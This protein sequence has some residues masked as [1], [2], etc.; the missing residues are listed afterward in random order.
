MNTAELGEACRQIIQSGEFID[1][2]PSDLDPWTAMIVQ[3]FLESSKLKWQLATRL[4][5]PTRVI[6]IFD[7]KL[8]YIISMPSGSYD[9]QPGDQ[10]Y[11]MIGDDPNND[12]H[13]ISPEAASAYLLYKQYPGTKIRDVRKIDGSCWT[14]MTLPDGSVIE[15]LFPPGFL[16]ERM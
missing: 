1:A 8:K 12:D 4:V 3:G 11:W 7:D 13:F 6:K 2:K 5:G 16:S 10:F 9:D 14:E 15:L